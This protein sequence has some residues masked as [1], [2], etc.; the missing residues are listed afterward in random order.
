MIRLANVE[1]NSAA[2]ELDSLRLKA[3]RASSA[4]DREPN[5]AENGDFEVS[6][7]AI[8]RAPSRHWNILPSKMS[9]PEIHPRVA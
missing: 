8:V 3:K 2:L 6:M 4:W 1:L 9:L 7:A 5:G